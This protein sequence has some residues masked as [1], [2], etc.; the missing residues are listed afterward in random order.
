M[1][2]SD[3]EAI[4]NHLARYCFAVDHGSADEIAELFWDDARLE[5][6]GT[7][8]GRDAIRRCYAQWIRTKRDPV[9]GLRHLIYVPLIDIDGDEASTQTY[10]DADAHTRRSGRTVLLR[11]L[12]RD[13]LHRRDGQWRFVERHIVPM[14]SLYDVPPRESNRS[15]RA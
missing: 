15:P 2:Q 10:V 7:H 11:S 13:R 9:E 6:D 8:L 4:R 14:R 12:Y 3:Y 5:F 1:P